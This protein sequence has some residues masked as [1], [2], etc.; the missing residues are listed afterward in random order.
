MTTDSI[1]CIIC[2]ILIAQKLGHDKTLSKN[3]PTFKANN[4]KSVSIYKKKVKSFFFLDKYVQFQ[5]FLV[6]EFPA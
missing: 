5:F 6:Y 1:L 4:I 3:L 2:I